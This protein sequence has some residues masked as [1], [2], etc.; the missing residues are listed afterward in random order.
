MKFFGRQK[1]KKMDD[2]IQ[3]ITEAEAQ[4]V[5]LKSDAVLRA[6]KIIEDAR[7]QSANRERIAAEERA[8]YR[9]EQLAAARL[10]AE[11]DYAASLAVRRKEAEE[12]VERASKNTDVIV[13]RIVGRL[14]GGNR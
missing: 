10:Q 8:A 6:G 2:I 13:G 7:T 1:R 3:S 5:Q 11:R 4:A 14:C 9:D 12:Y